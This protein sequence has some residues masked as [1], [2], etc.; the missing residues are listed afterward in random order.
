VLLLAEVMREH[1]PPAEGPEGVWRLSGLIDFAA[2]TRR[3]S[4]PKATAGS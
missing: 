2:A 1:L 4:S 3:C